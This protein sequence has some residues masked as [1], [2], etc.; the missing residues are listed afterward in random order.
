RFGREVAAATWSEATGTWEVETTDGEVFVT[1]ALVSGVGQLSRPKWPGL[2]GLA[3][4]R[5]PT[6][7][8]ARW[9]HD[10]DLDGRRVAVLGTGASAIQFVPGVVD[11]VA[12]MTVFQRSAPWVL[13]KGD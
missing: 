11:R 2:P 7:H 6:M 12:S 10:L 4:F 8:S 1:R 3:D 5:G 13:P 9:D